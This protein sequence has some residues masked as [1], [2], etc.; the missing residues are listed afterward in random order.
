MAIMEKNI[1]QQLK[2][3][4]W[5]S[6]MTKICENKYF[7]YIEKDTTIFGLKYEPSL[8]PTKHGNND[9]SDW[10]EINYSGPLPTRHFSIYEEHKFLSEFEL[11]KKF[12]GA[13]LEIGVDAYDTPEMGKSSTLL[14]LEN[15]L[16]GA[17]YVG[18][19]LNDKS[20]LESMFPNVY[21]IK[22]D[23]GDV[24]NNIN[25]ILSWGIDS[26]DFIF[27]DGWHSINA[28]LKDW[29]YVKLLSI[30]GIIAFH[31]V[32][33]HPGPIALY[34]AIDNEYFEKHKLETPYLTWGLAFATRLQ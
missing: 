30:G 27:I 8:I 15:K 12:G 28:I 1:I 6:N 10:I 3:G 29:Q 24:E 21:T 5:L 22:N 34:D 17:K 13:I 23:S 7:K 9:D 31:D 33:F 4:D 18:I 26:L 20:Y 14:L 11:V 19:D 25:Q 2:N 32:N 16:P